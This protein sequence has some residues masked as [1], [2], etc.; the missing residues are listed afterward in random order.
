MAAARRCV[1]AQ[2]SVVI[3]MDGARLH[4]VL[5]YAIR[6]SFVR[7][8]LEHL[9]YCPPPPES[10]GLARQRFAPLCDSARA[11]VARSAQLRQFPPS[12]GRVC[13]RSLQR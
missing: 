9:N 10:V 2:V 11:P 12:L 5:D 4:D 13:P 7:D 1:A 3:S 8:K 6:N